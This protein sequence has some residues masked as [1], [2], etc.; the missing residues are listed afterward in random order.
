MAYNEIQKVHS[1]NR[2]TFLRKREKQDNSDSF[3]LILTY[4]Q[5]LNKIREILKRTH[6]HTIRSSR[7]SAVLPSPPRVAF[8]NPETLKDNLVR[9]KL[10]ICDSKENRMRKIGYKCGN[11]N[12]DICNVLYL[13]NEFQ[14][15]VKVIT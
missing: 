13:R 9:S 8:H 12:C 7:L 4:H 14:S 11:I 3:S 6:R 10:G 1:V 5:A 15:T 2:E